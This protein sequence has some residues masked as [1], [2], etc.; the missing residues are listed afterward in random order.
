MPQNLYE[1]TAPG[2]HAR[3]W[4]RFIFNTVPSPS[5]S[6]ALDAASASASPQPVP[7]LFSKKDER[8]RA[9]SRNQCSIDFRFTL[10]GYLPIYVQITLSL[11]IDM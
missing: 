2:H 4:Q 6:H 8:E 10:K 11:T 3:R 1:S 7:L 9:Q 5:S